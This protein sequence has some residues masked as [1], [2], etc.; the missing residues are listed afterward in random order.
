MGEQHIADFR[1]VLACERK[2]HTGRVFVHRAALRDA[3]GFAVLVDASHACDAAGEADHE[4]GSIRLGAQVA[5]LPQLREH[6]RA[7]DAAGLVAQ[8]LF[9]ARLAPFVV[10]A[11]RVVLLRD[12]RALTAL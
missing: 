2:Q 1:A 10:G 11:V 3:I 7:L 4:A 12:A 8:V 5:G 9:R 6:R